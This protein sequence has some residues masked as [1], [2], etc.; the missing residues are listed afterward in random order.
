M[1]LRLT[2]DAPA[3]SVTNRPSKKVLVSMA[4][5][6]G[7][8]GQGSGGAAAYDFPGTSAGALQGLRV[9]A[10]SASD[11]LIHPDRSV[12]ADGLRILG[13][14]LTAASAPGQAVTVR[15]RGAVT[16]AAWAWDEGPVYVG[17]G[18]ELTQTVPPSGWLCQIGVAI[19]AT[20]VDID[21]QP[22]I[23]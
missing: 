9:V 2:I 11:Q 1:T 20:T 15:R 6:L 22:I 16:E 19:N 21:P 3:N 13:L 18:G 12:A 8:A 5:V 23:L 4:A 14:A 17:D 10:L 7:G